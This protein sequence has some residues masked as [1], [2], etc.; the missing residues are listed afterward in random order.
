[1]RVFLV[2]HGETE[3]NRKKLLQGR[4]N[5]P[6]N[7][8]GISQAQ[9]VREYFQEQQVDFDLV[10]SSPLARALQTAA[11]IVG[12]NHKIL[13]DDRLLEMDY[14]PYEGSSLEHPSPEIVKFFSDF[15]HNPTP[16][17]MESLQHVTERMGQ[18]M[19]SL[20]TAEADNVLVVTHAIAM[21]GA[22]EYL[23]PGSNGAYWSKYIG[24]CAV[25]RTEY[26]GMGYCVPKAM[27][28]G[29]Q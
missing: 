26:D 23:T 27:P 14:G 18:F 16:E 19:E 28:A 29:F 2:R 8:E 17:G 25:Y 7:K 4:S 9:E 6:L 12:R 11:I 10:F 21:K 13:T 24:T 15:I 1:M 5:A 20:R 22:L 3:K